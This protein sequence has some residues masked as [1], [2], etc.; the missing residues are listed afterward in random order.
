MNMVFEMPSTKN[1][2]ERLRGA[3]RTKSD[4]DLARALNMSQSAVSAWR[5]R[6]IV[7]YEACVKV[8]VE[9]GISL[10][11]LVFG[12]SAARAERE[13]RVY[14]LAVMRALYTSDLPEEKRRHLHFRITVE[15]DQLLRRITHMIE[16]DKYS[17]EDAFRIIDA[18]LQEL[19]RTVD[20]G[21]WA[22]ARSYGRSVSGTG[23][24]EK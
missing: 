24:D 7:P 22:K 11:E 9:K 20:S 8:A 12:V 16:Q 10:D 14:S 2:L 5:T 1:V 17:E 21:K 23:P 19:V 4:T 6:G 3:T 18:D 13:A 15:K